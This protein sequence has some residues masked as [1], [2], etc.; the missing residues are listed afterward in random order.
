MLLQLLSCKARKS[1]AGRYNL[2]PWLT[3]GL[4][5]GIMLIV[6]ALLITNGLCQIMTIIAQVLHGASA[7]QA[8]LLT[9][10]CSVVGQLAVTLVGIRI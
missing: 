6:I 1:H 2:G 10:G 7:G 9:V 5:Q 8:E 3:Q 4:T